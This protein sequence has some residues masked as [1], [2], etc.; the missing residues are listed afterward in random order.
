MKN[1]IQQKRDS[2]LSIIKV[3]HFNDF[4]DDEPTDTLDI[5]SEYINEMILNLKKE[6]YHKTDSKNYGLITQ[7]TYIKENHPT[8][9]VSYD[10]QN[11]YAYV[12]Y[13]N[14]LN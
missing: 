8:L 10:I 13:D 5:P 7:I 11:D 2:I 12:S 3:G 6:S 14:R 1:E 9:Y 4:F